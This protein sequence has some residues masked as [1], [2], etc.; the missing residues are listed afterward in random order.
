MI[1]VDTPSKYGTDYPTHI[2]VL[3]TNHEPSIV[4][5]D[6]E[7]HS[8]FRNYI[9]EGDERLAKQLRGAGISIRTVTERSGDVSFE[10]QKENSG[11]L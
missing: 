9:G 4:G 7:I 8:G 5:Q 6:I 2:N 11:E 10:L 1:A 3:W